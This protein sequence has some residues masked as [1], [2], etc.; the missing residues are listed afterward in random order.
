MKELTDLVNKL[1]R[2]SL[3]RRC[4]HG[5][6]FGLVRRVSLKKGKLSTVTIQKLDPSK[7][8]ATTNSAKY[9]GTRLVLKTLD[10]LE[11]LHVR[12]RGGCF[13]PLADWIAK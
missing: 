7:R 5:A 10:E 13:L 4:A 9:R 2:V 3:C 12:V 8:D 11:T 1:V 6:H